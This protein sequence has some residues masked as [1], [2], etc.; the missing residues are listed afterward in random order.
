[1]EL[2]SMAL[3]AQLPATVQISFDA[4]KLLLRK[5]CELEERLIAFDALGDTVLQLLW[6]R[7]LNPTVQ[8]IVD[9]AP[10]PTLQTK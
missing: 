5:D 3:E 10:Q 6:E 4:W 1:M 7:G 9:G 2:E 8:A